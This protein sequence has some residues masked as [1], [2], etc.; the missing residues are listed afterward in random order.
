VAAQVLVVPAAWPQKEALLDA[1]RE[2]LRALPQRRA[3]YPGAARRQAEAVR[4]LG[5]AEL[6]GEQGEGLVQRTLITGLDPEDAG[7]YGFTEEFFG[8]VLAVTELPGR[9]A[10]DF[11]GEAVRFSNGRLR[12]T[13]GANLIVHPATAAELGPELEDGIA[14]LRYGTVGVN[15]WVGIAFLLA[16]ATWGAYPGHTDEDIQSG[17]GVVHNAYLFS[18][19]E[20]T[21]VRAPFE[22]FPR[23]LAR[24][25]A[26]LLPRPP[27]FVTHGRADEVGRR[28]TRFAASPSPWQVPGLFAAALRG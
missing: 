23:T 24:G 25:R 18:R 26:G 2:V 17:R 19:P 11:L 20:K 1:V 3:Y 6:Y 14:A 4:A 15:G 7:S 16:E 21:V 13:L 12:G 5:E 22:P 27:W 9:T 28:L 10:G 8:S